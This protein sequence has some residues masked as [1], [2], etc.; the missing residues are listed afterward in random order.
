MKKELRKRGK[1]EMERTYICVSAILSQVLIF[2]FEVEQA[3]PV[4]MKYYYSSCWV[5]AVLFVKI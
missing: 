1:A 2:V 4:E 5:S 3:S